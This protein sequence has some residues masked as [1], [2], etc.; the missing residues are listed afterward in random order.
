VVCPA[1]G[2]AA[3]RTVAY[4]FHPWVSERALIVSPF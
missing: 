2:V 3:V 1:G 4:G